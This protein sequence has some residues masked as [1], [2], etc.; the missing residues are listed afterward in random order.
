[1]QK[2]FITLFFTHYVLTFPDLP[3]IAA[4]DGETAQAESACSTVLSILSHCDTALPSN[5]PTESV[6]S[7]LC[8]DSTRNID[9]AYAT[10]ASVFTTLS[11]VA[12][13]CNAVGDICAGIAT[14]AT[15]STSDMTSP[16][17]SITT[18]T[19]ASNDVATSAPSRTTSEP[20]ATTVMT[21][22]SAVK[23]AAAPSDKI[24]II[25]AMETMSFILSFVLGYL[26]FGA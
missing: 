7:C 1:M 14:E 20:T 25:Y 9:S 15:A 8:C 11:D 2:L 21:T 13:S 4:L 10:C 23:T 17:T 12:S 24:T 16:D 6:A 3:N 18:I 5:A 19:S 22:E 26:I